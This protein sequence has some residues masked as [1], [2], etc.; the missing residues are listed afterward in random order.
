M[1]SASF[2]PDVLR[3]RLELALEDAR[4]PPLGH[5]LEA[6][7]GEPVVLPHPGKLPQSA[8]ERASKHPF[9]AKIVARRN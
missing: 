6:L 7:R 9:L 5:L 4:R 8:S 3:L 2:F 1:D